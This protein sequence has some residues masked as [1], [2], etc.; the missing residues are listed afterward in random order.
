MVMFT[1]A[2]QDD[3]TTFGRKV[4]NRQMDTIK[5]TQFL[6][7]LSLYLSLGSLPGWSSYTNLLIPTLY[8][9]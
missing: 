7:D 1:T 8:N 4:N 3:N 9:W 5:H 2:A 6:L